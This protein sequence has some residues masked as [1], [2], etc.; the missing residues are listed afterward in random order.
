MVEITDI[1]IIEIG[2]GIVIGVII[3]LVVSTWRSTLKQTKE[4]TQMRDSIA[5]MQDIMDK[6]IINSDKLHARMEHKIDDLCDRMA[7]HE[8]RMEK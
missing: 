3:P 2:L 7:R 1:T 8:G 4:T 6:E 5:H